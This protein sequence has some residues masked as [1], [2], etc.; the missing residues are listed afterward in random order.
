M[1]KESLQEHFVMP[2]C[3]SPLDG[4]VR[5]RI[6]TWEPS[7]AG[8]HIWLTNFIC[9]GNVRYVNECVTMDTRGLLF[10]MIHTIL[11]F[12]YFVFV[13][14]LVGCLIVSLVSKVLLVTFCL[15]LNFY[16]ATILNSKLLFS[17]NA[18]LL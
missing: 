8:D 5:F 4:F 16:S 17:T 3:S 1:G 15:V 12:S 14:G 7:I 6:N 2:F 18:F 9:R 13:M 11:T 10:S